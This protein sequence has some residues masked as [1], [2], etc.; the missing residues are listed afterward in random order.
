MLGTAGTVGVIL[1]PIVLIAIILAMWYCPLRR[2]SHSEHVEASASNS[3]RAGVTAS[4][5]GGTTTGS[6]PGVD[7]AAIPY[8]APSYEL[9]SQQ[10]HR[11]FRLARISEEGG[12]FHHHAAHK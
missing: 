2:V 7:T 6:A 10:S 9:Q 11:S 3:G 1:V 5:T 12:P 8:V 4:G